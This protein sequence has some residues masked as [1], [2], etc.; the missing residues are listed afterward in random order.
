MTFLK[1]L[2]P[3]VFALA[4]GS[5]LADDASPRVIMHTS[6][7]S[8]V[9]ELDAA[10]APVTVSNFLA[11][12]DKGFY[13]GLIFHRVIPGFMVQGGGFDSDYKL[14]EPGA[15]IA[16]ESRNGLSNLRGTIA[17]ART[18]A[19]DSANSQFFINLADNRRLDASEYR[20]GYAVF[21]RVVEGMDN[22]DAIVEI[23]TGPAGPFG[24]DAPQSTVMIERIS[25][26]TSEQEQAVK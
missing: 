6:A 4:F 22:V 2:Q 26:V 14:R 21:G 24:Q 20:W 23:P 11:Y 15:P 8:I 16:N 18:A 25:R 3:V 7:G 5:A 19:P 9:I 17:M 1:L 10:N 12:V 13:D